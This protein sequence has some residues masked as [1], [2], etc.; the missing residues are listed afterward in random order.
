MKVLKFGGTSVAT[1]ES[2]RQVVAIVRETH[3]RGP[4]IVVVSA[5]GGVTNELLAACEK[6]ARRDEGYRQIHAALERRHLETARAVVA[7]R[8]QT[9]IETEV[10]QRCSDLADL[11][12]GVFLLREATARTL[13]SIGSYGERLAAVLVAAAMRAAGLDAEACDAR[14]L[15]LTDAGFGRAQVE[16]EASYARIRNYFRESRR[17]QVV[18]G[19]IAATAEGQTTTLGR[20]GSDYTAALLGAAVRADLVEIWT[21]VDGVMSADPR[22]VAAAV[23]LAELSYAEL[24]ELSHFGAK[25]VYPP[26]VHPARSQ[27]IPLLIKNTFHPQAPG[28]RV[29]EKAAPSVAPVRG[30]A[31]IRRVALMRFEGDGIVGVPGVAMRL[32][33]A[34]ARQGVSVILISQG[35]S[36]HSICFAVAPEDA[37]AAR[38]VVGSEFALERR[39]GI[40]DEL[41]VEDEMAVVA[42]VGEEMRERPG[43]AGRIFSVLGAHGVNVHAIAQGSSELNVSLVVPRAAEGRALG[44]I[45]DAF[46]AP[47]RQRVVVAIAGVGRV[48]GALLGQ[49]AHAAPELAAKE[50]L[51]LRL[52]AVASSRRMAVER[53]GFAPE[54]WSERLTNEGVELDYA[55]LLKQLGRPEGDVRIFVDCTAS[56]EVTELYSQL[57]ERGIGVVAA[58]KRWFAGPSASWRELR[59]RAARQ[60]VPLLF[61]ATVGAGLPVVATL[62]ALR[63]TGDVVQR[64][65]G[66]L[67]GTCNAVLDRVMSGERLSRAVEWAHAQGLTEPHPYDDLSGADVARKLCILARESGR[68]IELDQIEVEPLLPGARWAEMPLDT[69]WTALPEIDE[70]F[71]EHRRRA[72]EGGRILRYVASLDESGARV[73]LQA[74]EPGHPAATVTGP[75]NLIAFHTVRYHQAPLVVRGPGAGPEVTAAGVFGDI[76][77]AA[78]QLAGAQS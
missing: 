2:I 30:I 29:L 15:I 1:P 9:A 16:L 20:G 50:N 24:M 47:Y 76:L 52:A 3:A 74:V 26:T 37:D 69:F 62:I 48:G 28:T 27:G 14:Q 7:E 38:K 77:A 18:T 66:V 58:N 61:E 63:R 59:A 40:V 4:A 13:D 32:F 43:I 31:S 8:E 25:V 46:F 55:E 70:V 72:E 34:L 10:R 53:G 60:R 21:D 54:S 11:L 75:D 5:L 65:D 19:F 45:H 57:I 23:P 49:I 35:S 73:S 64:I 33:G 44:A 71:E 36:E 42:A 51:E 68:E 22:L 67:S 12:H 39:L 6:A 41:V 78:T 56:E 17:L